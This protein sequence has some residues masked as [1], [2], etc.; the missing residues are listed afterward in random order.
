MKLKSLLAGLSVF[1]VLS[2]AISCADK[3]EEPKQDTKA[4]MSAELRKKINLDSI[5]AVA[6]SEKAKRVTEDWI[7]YIAV[8]SEVED[9]E[10]Y[11]LLDVVNNSETINKVVDSLAITVPDVFET[12]AVN[13]RIITLQTH[14]KLLKENSDRTEPDPTEVEDL[15]AKLKLD[16]NNLN[17]QLN[18]VFIIEESTLESDS[19]STKNQ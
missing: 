6:L 8:N 9:L 16:F 15:S 18:E 4:K 2:L 11:T 7:M 3:K 17:I 19:N 10:E 5:K 13:A 12:N 14:A 1:A